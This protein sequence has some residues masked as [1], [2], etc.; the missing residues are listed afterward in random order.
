MIQLSELKRHKSKAIF[1]SIL[2][3]SYYCLVLD[4]KQSSPQ[5]KTELTDS[6]FTWM[7]AQKPYICHSLLK[8]FQ[9]VNCKK[10]EKGSSNQPWWVHHLSLL[11]NL[12][13][14]ETKSSENLL[15]GK[16]I[17]AT[18]PE[19]YHQELF[20]QTKDRLWRGMFVEIISCQ[21]DQDRGCSQ[22]QWRFRVISA[23]WRQKQKRPVF[24]IPE[25]ERLPVLE[26]QASLRGQ[27]KLWRQHLHRLLKSNTMKLYSDETWLGIQDTIKHSAYYSLFLLSARAS[28]QR[29]SDFS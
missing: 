2:L 19:V 10:Q 24:V 14:L 4:E 23:M 11:Y 8:Q 25:R 3:I 13:G 18:W 20:F 9:V 5:F 16:R 29:V 27:T 21:T 28:G 22:V 17:M 15:E 7:Q 1:L 12:H 6:R 26:L